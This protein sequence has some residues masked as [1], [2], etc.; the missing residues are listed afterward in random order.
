MV[1]DN[2]L[3]I[4]GEMFDMK[5]SFLILNYNSW[6]TTEKLAKKVQTFACV[7]RIV[8]VD[9]VSTDDSYE[10]L[11][12]MKSNKIDII[13]T[14]KNGGYSYGNNV[15]AQYCDSIGADIIFISN[16]DVDI[17]EKDIILLL[18]QFKATD[19]SLLTAVQYEFDGT[20]GQPPVLNKRTF[21]LDLLECCFVTRKFWAKKRRGVEVDYLQNV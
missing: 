13:R 15:G 1:C 5:I 11:L 16:P 7:D 3:K 6:K 20:I 21:G 18:E 2:K 19:Y 9:N 12:K 17:V 14:K 8:I 4:M 10:Q